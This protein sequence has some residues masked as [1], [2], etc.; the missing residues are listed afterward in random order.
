MSDRNPTVASLSFL[1]QKKMILNTCGVSRSGSVPGKWHGD[2]AS[3]TSCIS[4]GGV[5]S[6]EP[7]ARLARARRWRSRRLS[8]HVGQNTELPLTD[9]SRRPDY[10]GRN[11]ELPL[12]DR[13][14]RPDYAPRGT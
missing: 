7:S 14:R 5:S 12:T 4:A 10:V 11:T 3:T 13:S 8:P 2:G 6:A 9:R 1:D